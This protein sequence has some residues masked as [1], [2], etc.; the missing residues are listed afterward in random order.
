MENYVLIPPTCLGRAKRQ[1]ETHEG[2]HSQGQRN[3]V[4]V[5]SWGSPISTPYNH[6]VLIGPSGFVLGARFVEM[7]GRFTGSAP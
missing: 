3:G 7:A 5:G 4:R 6:L 1:N 2:L